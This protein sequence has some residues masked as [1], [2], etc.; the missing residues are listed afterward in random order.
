MHSLFLIGNL[1]AVQETVKIPLSTMMRLLSLI[2]PPGISLD[3]Y[4]PISYSII[5][6][7]NMKYSQ[8]RALF[9][10]SVSTSMAISGLFIIGVSSA[11]LN[12]SI[13][14]FLPISAS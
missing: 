10:F 11:S 5:S 12:S 13:S 4:S 3:V 1:K 9:P 2:Q 14:S 8:L 6:C 7:Y